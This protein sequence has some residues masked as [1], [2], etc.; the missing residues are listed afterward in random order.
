MRCRYPEALNVVR[1][2]ENSLSFNQL[3]TS[4]ADI[5]CVKEGDDGSGEYVD[6]EEVENAIVNSTPYAAATT[7]GGSW[8]PVPWGRTHIGHQQDEEDDE[9]M[10]Y[11][12]VP[13]FLFLSCCA[14]FR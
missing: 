10:M 12:K 6:E 11:A 13:S 8:F 4:R 1:F 2:V 9:L 5:P 14:L 3:N 7:M